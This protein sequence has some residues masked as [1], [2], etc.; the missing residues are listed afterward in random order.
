MENFQRNALGKGLSALIPSVARA[1]GEEISNSTF[2]EM[3]ISKIVPNI[4]QPR[5]Q[6]SLVELEELAESIKSFGLIQ[7]ISVSKMG[8]GTFRIIAGE[9][10]W[11]AAQIAGIT[12]IPVIIK[13]MS[14][15]DI[16]VVSIIENIQRQNLTAVEEANA[17]Y[18]LM[19][20]F[21]YTQDQL[22]KKLSKSR[23]HI[24]NLL[25][26]KN[27]PLEVQEMIA[28]RKLSFGHAKVLM[29][30][31]DPIATAKISLMKNFTVKQL[32]SYINRGSR[33]EKDKASNVF[34]ERVQSIEPHEE[35][36]HQD[37]ANDFIDL[38]NS[39]AKVLGCRVKIFETDNGGR[40]MID[41]VD[42]NQLDHIVSRLVLQSV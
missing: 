14:D 22:A 3:S 18:E 12:H 23:S 29:N 11:R 24:A 1:N 6:F 17:I 34:I 26:L 41:F 4:N 25:R 38:E 37:I 27:L 2:V 13:D 35:P 36:L 40:L 19:E 28:S 9:R 39:L 30:A 33:I 15:N 20:K 7:P 42:L 10:R 31:S 21:N 8:D 5:Q 32:E 16:L